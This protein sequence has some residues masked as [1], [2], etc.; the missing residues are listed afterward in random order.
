MT[1][2]EQLEYAAKAAG[3]EIQGW[4]YEGESPI[5]AD[6]GCEWWGIHEWNPR[7][8]KADAFD[9]MVKLKIHLSYEDFSAWTMATGWIHADNWT[10]E[11]SRST[12]EKMMDAITR[13]A[14]EIGRNM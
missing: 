5:C 12:E 11:D 10:V 9:L 2:R 13:V 6:I 8:N 3:I 4:Y 1:E 14:A 7:K